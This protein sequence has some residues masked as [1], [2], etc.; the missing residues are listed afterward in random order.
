MTESLC[1]S[2]DKIILIYLIHNR[3]VPTFEEKL[4]RPTEMCFP[5]MIQQELS[6]P[7]HPQLSLLRQKIV[8]I[9]FRG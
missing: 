8:I 5:P 2:D 9:H 3:F 6:R 7:N 1:I 4:N